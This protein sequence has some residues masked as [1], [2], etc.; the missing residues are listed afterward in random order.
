MNGRL[1]ADRRDAGRRL[2]EALGRFRDRNPVVLALPRGGV[3]VG[4]EIAAALH[5]PL[6][7]VMVRKIGAPQQPELAAAAVVDGDRPETVRNDRVIDMLGI[8]ERYLEVETGKQLAEIERRRAIYV[9]GLPRPALQGSTVLVV[10]D[11]IATGST[12]RA[13]AHGVARANPARVVIAVPVAPPDTVDTLRS[14][15][16]EV[17]CLETPAGFAAIGAFYADFHQVSDDEVID[18]LR[19]AA[20]FQK[21]EQAS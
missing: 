11:G 2:A 19:K 5:C 21:E 17:V 15:V 12:I 8:S 20:D 9:S 6:D 16:D 1:F 18:C 3:P 10:D 4:Y 14:E 13:A 7:V